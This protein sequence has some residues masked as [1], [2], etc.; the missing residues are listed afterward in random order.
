MNQEQFNE[1]MAR[2]DAYLQTE[3]FSVEDLKSVIADKTNEL[4]DLPSEQ[5]IGIAVTQSLRMTAL[6]KMLWDLT[7]DKK[8]ITL[9]S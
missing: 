3:M 2:V 4:I 9:D 6:V 5:I 7:G 1:M 8:I